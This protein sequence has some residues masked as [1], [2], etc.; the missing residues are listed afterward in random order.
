MMETLRVQQT[1]THFI[2][3]AARRVLGP[4]VWQNGAKNRRFGAHIDLTHFEPP[5]FGT[6]L[7]I[8]CVANEM[9]V[10]GTRVATRSHY[11]DVRLIGKTKAIFGCDQ[12]D[13]EKK[14]VHFFAE[15][16]RFESTT[17]NLATEPLETQ[18]R[19]GLARG[20]PAFVINRADEEPTMFIKGLDASIAG[21]P[22]ANQR[23]IVVGPSFFLGIVQPALIAPLAAA[24]EP[25]AKEMGFQII[26]GK[27]P[28]PMGHIEFTSMSFPTEA[29]SLGE[30][31]RTVSRIKSRP[32]QMQLFGTIQS[33]ENRPTAIVRTLAKL[34]P[35][36]VTMP[37]ASRPPAP[38]YLVPHLSRFHLLFPDRSAGHERAPKV[39]P[40]HPSAAYCGVDAIAKCPPRP[41]L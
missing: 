3:A 34:G 29:L 24:R 8:D 25:L 41:T 17:K 21:R 27:Q 16:N 35:L 36:T 13:V 2:A 18:V 5:S 30:N 28:K 26:A 20:D 14:C 22:E 9:I 11:E 39:R 32:L 38:A 23:S 19:L 6:L 33:I 15:Q 12:G 10:S 4:H 7:E 1:E 31:H 40:H 37:S